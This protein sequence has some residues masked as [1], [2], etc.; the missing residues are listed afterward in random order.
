MGGLRI[1]RLV[2]LVLLERNRVRNFDRHRPDFHIDAEIAQDLHCP[3]V[4]LRDGHRRK[5][6]LSAPLIAGREIKRMPA[7][8]EIDLKAARLVGNWRCGEASGRHV[9]RHLPPVIDHRLE[10][11]TNLPDN[12]RPHVQRRAGVLPL[13]KRQIGPEILG[14]IFGD[15]QEILIQK[16]AASWEAAF[17]YLHDRQ[18]K[19]L[20]IVL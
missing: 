1:V 4:E 11:E 10:R 17:A 12:L 20:L 8:I 9:K 14:L 5:R 6:E 19:D 2:L 13:R 15:H 16:N 18:R 7:E 3:V